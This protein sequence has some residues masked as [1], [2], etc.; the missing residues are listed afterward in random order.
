MPAGKISALRDEPDH[1][2]TWLR[3]NH[4]PHAEP[5]MA[6]P[7]TFAPRAVFGRYIQSLLASVSGIGYLRAKVV[8]L[9]SRETERY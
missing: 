4:D 1:F 7:K 5:M 8:D 2:L 9:N 6:Q 3:A